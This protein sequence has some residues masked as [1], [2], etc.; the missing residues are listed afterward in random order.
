[1]SLAPAR[2]LMDINTILQ[3]VGAW[4]VEDRLRLVHEVWDGLVDSG[5][6]PDLTEEQRIELDRRLDEDDAD[7]DDGVPWVE[8]K[9]RAL[10]RVRR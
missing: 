9:A 3:E 8:V 6:D 2:S 10:A 4:P 1:M 7:P 5:Y